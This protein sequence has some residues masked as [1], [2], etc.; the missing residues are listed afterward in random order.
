MSR[1]TRDFPLDENVRSL[2]SEGI[3]EK[4]GGPVEMN[5][6]SNIDEILREVIDC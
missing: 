6:G 4:G 3:T 5:S 2:Y 1:G